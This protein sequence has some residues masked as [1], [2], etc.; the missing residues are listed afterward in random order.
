M[1]AFGEKII[2]GSLCLLSYSVMSKTGSG[3]HL[4]CVFKE[5]RFAV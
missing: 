2:L 5:E 4:G 3:A 1:N